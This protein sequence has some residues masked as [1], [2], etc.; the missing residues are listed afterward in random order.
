MASSRT[1]S[2]IST[3]GELPG[4]S[5]VLEW[6]KSLSKNSQITGN[7][8]PLICAVQEDNSPT[9]G[10]P[11]SLEALVAIAQ[12]AFDV[13][14]PASQ[15]PAELGK[16]LLS[17]KGKRTIRPDAYDIFV[18]NLERP[19]RFLLLACGKSLRVTTLTYRTTEGLSPL[20]SSRGHTEYWGSAGIRAS[21]D[22]S[23][24]VIGANCGRAL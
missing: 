3:Q 22:V 4:E 5:A 21:H 8:Y 12:E 14:Q 24:M 9:P 23:L 20:L 6:L 10:R 11:K 19:E 16:A 18:E 1:S 7:L 2:R 15:P 13:R 17:T